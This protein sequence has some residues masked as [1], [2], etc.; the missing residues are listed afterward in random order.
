MTRSGNCVRCFYLKQRK[1]LIPLLVDDPLWD[2]K[3]YIMIY[4]YNIVLIPLLV[5]D[6]LWDVNF[7]GIQ[8]LYVGVLIPLLV[9][10][11]L[12]ENA[13]HY[14]TQFCWD[15]LNPSFSG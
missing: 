1:V 7:G 2:S 5:D 15:S 3:I 14:V 13:E 11:P 8:E 10:D 9:D 4:A 12:W 6:P